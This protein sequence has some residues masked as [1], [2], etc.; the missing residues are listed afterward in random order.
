[1]SS[2]TIPK[3]EDSPELGSPSETQQYHKTGR[4]IRRGAGQKVLV[5]GYVDSAVIEEDADEPIETPSEDED[6]HL[7]K[8]PRKRKRTRSPSAPPPPLDPLIRHEV[9][10]EATDDEGGNF[11]HV[12]QVAPI[13]LQFNVPLGF[14]GPLMVKL[15]PSLLVQGNPDGTVRNPG[16]QIASQ[17]RCSTAPGLSHQVLR[18]FW[19][20]LC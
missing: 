12:S 15:D 1:M 20:S 4:P 11:H 8:P 5:A 9:P 2:N 14:H 16:P 7:I 17:T 19:M 10:D 6:G 13:I 18:P 3:H